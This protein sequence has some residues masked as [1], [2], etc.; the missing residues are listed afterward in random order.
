MRMVAEKVQNDCAIA[1]VRGR[2]QPKIHDYR[3]VAPIGGPQ[4]HNVLHDCTGRG[5]VDWKSGEVAPLAN[6]AY[7]V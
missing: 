6:C 2:A 4:G 1:E 5:H 3:V 7:C